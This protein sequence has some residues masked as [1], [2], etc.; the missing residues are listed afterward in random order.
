MQQVTQLHPRHWKHTQLGSH[1]IPHKL[2]ANLLVVN[3]IETNDSQLPK[4][5]NKT[6]NHSHMT[7]CS[8]F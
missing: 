7:M 5:S 2:C 4:V 6:Q 8:T 3:Q 1:V